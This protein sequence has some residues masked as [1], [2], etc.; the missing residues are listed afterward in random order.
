MSQNPVEET[1][2]NDFPTSYCTATE[3]TGSSSFSIAETVI[4]KMIGWKAR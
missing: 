3:G 4:G 2:C 1:L